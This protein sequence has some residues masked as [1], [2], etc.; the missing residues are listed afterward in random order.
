MNVVMARGVRI[1]AEKA[2]M[3]STG[4]TQGDQKQ[5]EIQVTTNISPCT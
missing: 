4:G 3:T 5:R 1:F 2:A